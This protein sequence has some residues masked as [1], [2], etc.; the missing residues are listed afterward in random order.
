MELVLCTVLALYTV[1]M[2]PS[3]YLILTAVL[4]VLA[5]LFTQ[6]YFSVLGVLVIMVLLNMLNGALLTTVESN[7]YG[8]ISGPTGGKINGVESFQPKD[9]VSIH[10][11]IA[12]DKK[13]QPLQPKINKVQGVLEAPSILNSLQI[14]QIDSFENGAS[15]QT[16]PAVVGIKESIRTPAEG[17]VPHVPSPD[18]GAPRGNPFLQNGEDKESVKKALDKTLLT[19]DMHEEVG[20]SVGPGAP[21]E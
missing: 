4:S 11:R 18:M 12:S 20:A 15:T 16:L 8:A 5:Y 21:V 7:R 19:D 10:Q 13:G 6:S 1:V 9:P 2:F 17:F 14:S 3:G